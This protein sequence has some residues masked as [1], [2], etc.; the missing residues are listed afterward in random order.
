MRLRD[1]SNDK[2]VTRI[3]GKAKLFYQGDELVGYETVERFSSDVM[4]TELII[5]SGERVAE[6]EETEPLPESKE[7]KKEFLAEKLKK[8][9]KLPD[10][11]KTKSS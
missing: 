11:E 4:E 1:D 8:P 2:K 10:P 9:E 6:K 3:D 7:L 5:F